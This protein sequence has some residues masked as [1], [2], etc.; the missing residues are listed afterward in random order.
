MTMVFT[1]RPALNL[2]GSVP[3]SYYDA[4]YWEAGASS[5]K[6]SYNGNDYATQ[7]PLCQAW[8][9]DTWKRW[10]PFH[11]YLELGCGR[12]WAIYGFVHLPDL[13]VNPLGVDFSHYAIETA[14]PDVRPFLTEHDASELSFLADGSAD[15]IFSNDFMEHLTPF[16]AE[17][18][19]WECRRI[20][21]RRIAHLISI[22]DGADLPDGQVPP[23]QDQSH[24]N[25]KSTEW[26]MVLFGKVFN[27]DPPGSWKI[28]LLSHGRTIE[29]DVM[30]R[31]VE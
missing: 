27:P 30:R 28:S 6:G 16:Q 23:D 20:S 10:G 14:H 9:L 8:A 5:G 7:L 1:N 19:L 29:F 25:L 11:N 26:W 15:L 18:C 2:D 31:E 21:K 3:A 12:G 22:A 17:R 4:E 24:V 13:A